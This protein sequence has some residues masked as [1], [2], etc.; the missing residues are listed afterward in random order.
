MGR[1]LFLRAPGPLPELLLIETPTPSG[2]A[3]GIFRFWHFRDIAIGR[4]DMAIA[5][6]SPV[7]AHRKRSLFYEFTA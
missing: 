4:R 5:V 1:S 2:T 7:L 6:S 3:G